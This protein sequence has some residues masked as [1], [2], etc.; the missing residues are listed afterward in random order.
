MPN[1]RRGP[2]GHFL[3]AAGDCRCTRPLRNVGGWHADLWGQGLRT[4]RIRTVQL[5][6]DHL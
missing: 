2:C 6:T 3:P 5:A 1:R 4:G